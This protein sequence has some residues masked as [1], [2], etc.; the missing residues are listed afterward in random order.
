M[1]PDFELLAA[2]AR[3]VLDLSDVP[4]PAALRLPYPASTQL[5]FDRVVL[6]CLKQ[7]R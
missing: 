2:V 4:R 3:G 6:T 5:A 1:S 7:D